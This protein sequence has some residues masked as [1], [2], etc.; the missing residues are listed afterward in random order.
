MDK[1]TREYI[2]RQISAL[3]LARIERGGLQSVSPDNLL[4]LAVD[5]EEQGLIEIGEALRKFA[6]ISNT[7]LGEGWSEERIEEAFYRLM[8]KRRNLK[9]SLSL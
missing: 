7:L 1:Q 8:E 5:A 9:C 3:Q 6:D 4:R 2:R